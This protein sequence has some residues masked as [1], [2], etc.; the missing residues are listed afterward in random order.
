MYQYFKSSLVHR[1]VVSLAGGLFFS[2]FTFSFLLP[3][4]PS[5]VIA[6]SPLLTQEQG[7]HTNP[8]T[9]S[10]PNDE[11]FDEY[12]KYSNCGAD[13]S[14]VT[15]QMTVLQASD[16]RNGG[17]SDFMLSLQQE[18]VDLSSLSNKVQSHPEL[19]ILVI[20]QLYENQLLEDYSVQINVES[21]FKD[22]Q[23][24]TEVTETLIDALLSAN[25]PQ[26]S[27][28]VFEFVSESD[29]DNPSFLAALITKVEEEPSLVGHQ[30]VLALLEDL[31]IEGPYQHEVMIDSYLKELSI[32]P[33][34]V[35]RESA[36][37]RRLWNLSHSDQYEKMVSMVNN[38]LFDYS[39]A[40]R[41]YM[42]QIIEIEIIES[43]NKASSEMIN[44]LSVLYGT[45]NLPVTEVER[46]KID[47][48]LTQLQK[49][50]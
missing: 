4:Q 7:V 18:E 13:L 25:K 48:L 8:I 31:D 44:N 20:E 14:K 19:L 50:I 23:F 1:L 11:C 27:K 26:L 36:I 6:A 39:S 37:E 43:H 35:I 24:N 33:D 10:Y 30:R 40:V 41:H 45:Q 29:I 5:H 22:I 28:I 12:S 32:H 3:E 38:Y 9:F 16:N 21:I 47:N 42:Y 15:D 17:L 34:D 49:R 46:I 2:I